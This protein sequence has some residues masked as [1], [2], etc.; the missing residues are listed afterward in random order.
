MSELRR[1][2]VVDNRPSRLKVHPSALAKK[3][4][5]THQKVNW[6]YV[7]FKLSLSVFAAVFLQQNTYYFRKSQ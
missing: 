6:N 5:Y 7:C 1:G 4:C 3:K 2:G